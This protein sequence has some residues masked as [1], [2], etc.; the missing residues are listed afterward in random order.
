MGAISRLSP[1]TC[2]TAVLFH[3]HPTKLSRSITSLPHII[4]SA[5]RPPARFTFQHKDND[6][7]TLFCS[8]LLNNLAKRSRG[9]MRTLLLMF[10]VH[11]VE[12]TTVSTKV[13]LSLLP[14]P[15]GDKLPSPPIK[16]PSSCSNWDPWTSA[17]A[18]S[19]L[20]SC[21]YH[22]NDSLGKD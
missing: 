17:R 2:M 9:F 10:E 5:S 16:H 15:G 7:R 13:H 22:S 3:C 6:T 11:G 1:L 21:W 12:I 20:L 19:H 4:H 14:P 18:V 8:R